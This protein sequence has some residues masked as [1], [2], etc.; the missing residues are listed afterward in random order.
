MKRRSLAVSLPAANPTAVV[1]AQAIQVA[2]N[3]SQI[4]ICGVELLL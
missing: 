2:S 1:V 4:L 3:N